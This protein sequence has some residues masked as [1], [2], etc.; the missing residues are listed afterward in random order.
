[1]GGIFSL[2][3]LVFFVF[4][5]ICFPNFVYSEMHRHLLVPKS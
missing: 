5:K 4:S 1:M 2:L 3:G